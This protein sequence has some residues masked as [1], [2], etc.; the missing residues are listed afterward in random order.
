M[1]RIPRKGSYA[2]DQTA[3]IVAKNNLRVKTVRPT[4]TSTVRETVTLASAKPNVLSFAE[5][6]KAAR[7]AR[8]DNNRAKDYG[9]LMADCLSTPSAYRS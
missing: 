7:K 8:R 1:S 5:G 9:W 4:Q 6:R 2:A 3:E